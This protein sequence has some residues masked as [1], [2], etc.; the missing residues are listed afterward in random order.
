MPAGFGASAVGRRQGQTWEQLELPRHAQGGI[1]VNLGNTA[2]VLARRRIVVIH[3]AGVF[4]RPESY[5]VGFRLWYRILHHVLSRQGTRIV[6]VSEFA[7]QEL[8]NF[9]K[10]PA[11]SVSIVSEGADHIGRLAAQDDALVS[12]GLRPLHYVLAVGNLAPHKNLGAL[13]QVSAT[14]AARGT[15]LVIT[16]GFNSS[17]FSGQ[18][19]GGLPSDASYIGRVSDEALKALYTHAACFVF[20]SLYEGFGLP[21]VEAMAC[22]CPV[23]AADVP[24]L[25]ETCGDAV[26][27]C[28]PRDP[29]DI[30]AKVLHVIEDQKRAAALRAAGLRRAARY[31]WAD[32]ADALLSVI[33]A[34]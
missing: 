11:D 21:A 16:G 32:A 18:A 14:L 1:L 7:R 5:S 31:R 28:S 13:S 24:G 26:L 20:P 19:Q 25:R 6:A 15:P 23:V 2:P 3:D 29:A 27:Y 17:T 34:Q 8:V 10:I 9:L 33:S 30:M 4:R 12:A 22:G